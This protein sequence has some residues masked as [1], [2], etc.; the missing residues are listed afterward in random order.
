VID[1]PASNAALRA[2]ELRPA[3]EGRP[4]A[5]YVSSYSELSRQVRAAGLL[6]R[7]YGYYW[8]RIGAAVLVFALVWLL[9][10]RLGDSW[11]VLLP[12]VALGVVTAQIG[13]LGHDA[14]HRQVFASAGWNEW[15]ARVLSGVFAGLSYG[16][17]QRKHSRHHSA[18]NQLG[19]DPD[20]GSGVL[21]MTPQAMQERHGLW[22]R[23]ARR[24]G[25][26]MFL[27][28]PGE[29]VHLHIQGIRTVLGRQAVERRWVEIAFMTVRLVGFPAALLLLMS[30][31]K[32]AAF[33]A[34]Q[35]SLFGVLVGGAFIPNHIGR[36]IV[37]VGARID[38]L[39]RQVVMSRNVRGGILV[40][41]F[42][43]GLNHQIEHHL[44]PNMARPNLRRARRM[45]QE[46][47]HRHDVEYT[48]TSVL[49]AFRAAASYLNAV[50]GRADP[51]A[52]PLV[53]M[54]RG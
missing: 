21:A 38:F 52:C 26:W 51:F 8:S 19:R 29:G 33:V 40:D 15:T 48:E 12:A 37:P 13:F 6:R 30:P 2:P 5:A 20:I 25:W 44:F 36:P 41:F 49:G 34:V 50:G 1:P 23:I 47:C 24:Q 7:A 45:V 16:W 3:R 22:R 17:W 32:A 14:A 46:H 11:W 43:G 54:Y 27:L 53:S 4:G 28:L 39:H 10:V 9:V 31:G 18:P 42:M 35:V